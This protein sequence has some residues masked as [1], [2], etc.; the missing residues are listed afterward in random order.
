[1][2]WFSACNEQT[3]I[4]MRINVQVS[5]WK[6]PLSLWQYSLQLKSCELSLHFL[7]VLWTLLFSLLTTLECGKRTSSYF[8]SDFFSLHSEKCVCEKTKR[9]QKKYVER[10][11]KHVITNHSSLE[12]PE[13]LSMSFAK[14]SV[15]KCA[16]PARDVHFQLL[17]ENIKLSFGYFMSFTAKA[18][19]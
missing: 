1:M 10:V 13:L 15:N 16:G 9:V 7:I 3:V 8:I 11:C 18:C 14:S 2:E 4:D 6:Y 12:C 19:L 17:F 5:N